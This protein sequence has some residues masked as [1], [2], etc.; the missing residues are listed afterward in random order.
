MRRPKRDF[1]H[2]RPKTQPGYPMPESAEANWAE[3]PGE[4]EDVSSHLER[5]AEL[6]AKLA[7]SEDNW[8]RAKAETENI[9]RRSQE[10]IGKARK[11]SIEQFASEMLTVKDSLEAALANENQSA[12]TLHSGVELTLKQLTA[13]FERSGIQE[14]NP[15]GE[16]FDP[17][18][19]Q[20]IQIVESEQEPNTV[21]LVLQKGYRLAER[22]LRPAMVFV[23]K[24]KE[25]S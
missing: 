12:E 13:A 21:A 7:V 9:R 19:H 24:S 1:S 6:E 10:E 22:V 15:L 23:T 16:K 25:S 5:I 11:F 17:N 20:A 3:V 8:L 18:W 14:L 2:R 4:P